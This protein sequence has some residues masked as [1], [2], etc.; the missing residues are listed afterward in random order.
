M[1]L[2][3]NRPFALIGLLTLVAIATVVMACSSGDNASSTP[4]HSAAA[5]SSGASST[6]AATGTPAVSACP[7][8]RVT[9]TGRQRTFIGLHRPYVASQPVVDTQPWNTFE[10]GFVVRDQLNAEA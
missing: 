4:T 7:P 2:L 6:A 10:L 5:T 1:Q 9:R 8:T 3:R